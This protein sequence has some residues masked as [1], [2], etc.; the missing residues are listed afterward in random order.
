MT[1]RRTHAIIPQA[2][3]TPSIKRIPSTPPVAVLAAEQDRLPVAARARDR[4]AADAPAGAQAAPA[5]GY[6]AKAATVAWAVPAAAPVRDPV[7]RRAHRAC[8]TTESADGTT[9][10]SAWKSPAWKYELFRQLASRRLHAPRRW[11]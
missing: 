4:W 2:D 3:Q 9:T 6:P 11:C 7:E 1:H 10:A 5:A 8:G